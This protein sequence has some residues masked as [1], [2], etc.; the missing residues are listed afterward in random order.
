[1]G[2]ILLWLVAVI[3]VAYAISDSFNIGV[4]IL[5]PFLARTEQEKH[6]RTFDRASVAWKSGLATSERKA[7][8][9]LFPASVYL[10]AVVFIWQP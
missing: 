3:I 9:I 1:M 5:H 2:F 7:H 6:D 8:C 4:G 10:S